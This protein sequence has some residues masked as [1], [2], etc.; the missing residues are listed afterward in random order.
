MASERYPATLYF[1]RHGDA[2][3][4]GRHGTDFDRP[5]TAEGRERMRREADA[6][7]RLDLGL[8][9][10]LT[11][12]LV[13]ARQTAEIVAD[14]SQ[15]RE[16]LFEDVRLG[17]AFGLEQLAAIVGAQPA[18]GALMLVGHEPS[19]SAAIGRLIGGAAVEMKKGSLARVDLSAGAPLK[20]ELL[21]LV[22]PRVLLLS[23]ATHAEPPSPKKSR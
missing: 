13:R 21:W 19:L 11:S 6:I 3:D 7:A 2:A 1:L 8:D 12:P 22:P 4:A 20:G 10:I 15:L 18:A 17:A 5:L 9:A 16:A 23:Q 14:A